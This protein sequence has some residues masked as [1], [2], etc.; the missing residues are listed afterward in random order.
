MTFKQFYLKAK[1][2]KR[3]VP[4]NAQLFIKEI[5]DYTHKSEQ[6][7]RMWLSGTQQPD[8]LTKAVLATKFK[9]PANELFPNQ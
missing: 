3:V 1:A 8:E 4:T 9:T 7:V 5:A 6:T 2:R